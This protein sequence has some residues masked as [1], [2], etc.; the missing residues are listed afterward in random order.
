M[1]KKQLEI[2]QGNEYRN[3]TMLI[4]RLPLTTEQKKELNNQ[5]FAYGQS[6]IANK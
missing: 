5:V 4:D 2:H 6:I 1:V 3:L